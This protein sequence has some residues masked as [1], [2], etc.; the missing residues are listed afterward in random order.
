MG[1]RERKKQ[2]TAQ[3]IEDAALRLFSEQGFDATTI[4]DIADAA[5]IA[6]RTFFSYFPS[7]ESVLFGDFD[8]TFQSLA[9]HLDARG[10]DGVLDAI[11]VWIVQLVQEDGLPDERERRRRHVIE[12]NEDLRAHE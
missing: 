9:E 1:L 4:A 6:P 3:A 2:R 12:A 8:A 5:E 7:K 11:R 10:D